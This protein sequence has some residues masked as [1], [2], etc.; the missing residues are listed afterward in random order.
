VK[1]LKVDT[2]GVH[3]T[4]TQALDRESAEDLET[5]AAQRWNYQ[6]T[7]NYGSPEISVSDPKRRGKD[8]LEIRS[9]KL[10]K[11]GRTVTLKIADLKPVMQQLI[12]FKN[13]LA[14]DGTK[15]SQQV[16]HTINVLQ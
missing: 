2:R 14:S 8:T 5:Y 13:L 9:A 12:T 11:D 3:L 7:S 10:S 16:M 15:I 6:R 1:G 4:F